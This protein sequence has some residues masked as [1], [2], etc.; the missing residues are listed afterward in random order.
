MKN[1][2]D[3]ISID[4]LD[5]ELTVE[6]VLGIKADPTWDEHSHVD[7]KKNTKKIA[8]AYKSRIAK[9]PEMDEELQ[10]R[11]LRTVE[12]L[13]EEIKNIKSE[14]HYKRVA[15]RLLMLI[16]LLLGYRYQNGKTYHTP[17]FIQNLGHE[18]M[19][20]EEWGE[21]SDAVRFWYDRNSD[22][23]DIWKQIISDL[24]GRGLTNA[25]IGVILSMTPQKIARIYRK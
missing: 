22:V 21:D 16:N 3:E 8:Q 1:K 12:S 6:M 9:L 5:Y 15:V 14:S 20:K 25:Q 13:E 18:I 23:V 10:N 11:L 24:K 4:D 19:T 17:F 7:F 2:S